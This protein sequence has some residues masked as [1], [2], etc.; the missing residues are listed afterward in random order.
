MRNP[1]YNLVNSMN[2]AQRAIRGVHVIHEQQ[3]MG[4]RSQSRELTGYTT[5]E[6]PYYNSI[7]L[8]EIQTQ[9]R[10]TARDSISADSLS[11]DYV[12]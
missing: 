3:E 9:E 2:C 12:F 1:A 8:E 10:G 4:L 7:R 6:E 11:Y 5:T